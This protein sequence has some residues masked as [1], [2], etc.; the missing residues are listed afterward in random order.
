MGRHSIKHPKS[1]LWSCFSTVVDDFIC[2]WM[3]K[4]DYISW[5]LNKERD[6]IEYRLDRIE[7]DKGHYSYEDACEAIALRKAEEIDG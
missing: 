1:G 5:L 4:E 7:R 3:P 6:E 2:D